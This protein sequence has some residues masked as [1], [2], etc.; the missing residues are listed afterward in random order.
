MVD[1]ISFKDIKNKEDIFLSPQVKRKF[2][3][4]EKDASLI[5]NA[6]N[7]NK[8]SSDRLNKI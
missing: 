3:I 8:I 1:N 6:D 2:E 5:P 4:Y 7:T